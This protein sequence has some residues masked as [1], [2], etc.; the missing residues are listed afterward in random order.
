MKAKGSQLSEMIFLT[1]KK[2][3]DNKNTQ[4]AIC[5]ESVDLRGSSSQYK[6]LRMPSE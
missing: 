4:L 2:L 5:T 1:F 6:M 3:D